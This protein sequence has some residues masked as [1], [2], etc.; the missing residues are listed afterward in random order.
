[1]ASFRAF[2][3]YHFTGIGNTRGIEIY[4]RSFPAFWE[5]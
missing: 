1:M 4:W 5:P 2:C 3:V